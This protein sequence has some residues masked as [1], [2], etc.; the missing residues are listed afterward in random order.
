MG[1][2]G[3]GV[4][5]AELPGLAAKVYH[6]PRPEHGRRLE[7]MLAS[8][9]AGRPAFTWPVE[10]LRS[11]AGEVVG[12]LM[13]RLAP[14]R[15]PLAELFERRTRRV[16]VPHFTYRDLMAT[17]RSL[18]EC[19]AAV[20]RRGHVVGDLDEGDILAGPDARVTLVDTDSFQVTSP[21]TGERFRCTTAQPDLTPPELQGLRPADVDRAPEHDRFGL[22]VILFQL[23]MEGAHP[24][25]GVCAARGASPSRSERIRAGEFAY[26]PGGACRP[27]PLSPPF[28]LLDRGLRVLFTRCFVD[29]HLRPSAR[30]TP[31][32]WEHALARAEAELR[33][34]ATGPRHVYGSH[35]DACP[36][37]ERARLVPGG[38]PFP[39]NDD[40]LIPTSGAQSAGA[41]PPVPASAAGFAPP[42][43]APSVPPLSA[44]PVSPVSA[45][46][47]ASPLSAGP[48]VPPPL[49]ADRIP[50]PLP[51]DRVP[52]PIPADLIP[53]LAT[54]ADRVPPPIPTDLIPAQTASVPPPIPAD[55]VPPPLPPRHVPPPLP[56]AAPRVPPSV[57]GQPAAPGHA[58]PADARSG[59]NPFTGL[60]LLLAVAG[61][62][63][64]LR[65]VAWALAAVSAVL[66]TVFAHRW[67]GAGQLQV[68]AAAAVI[69]LTLFMGR[70][71]TP[72]DPETTR[73]AAAPSSSE[74]AP[75][76]DAR[77]SDEP[78][79]ASR[80]ETPPVR[81]PR[82]TREEATQD[83]PTRDEPARAAPKPTP[84]RAPKSEPT[85]RRTPRSELE[86]EP[87]PRRASRPEPTP[88]RAPKPRETPRTEPRRTPREPATAPS[89]TT[90]TTTTETRRTPRPEAAPRSTPAVTRRTPP[91]PA[92]PSARELSLVRAELAVAQTL[93]NQGA[94]YDA[95]ISLRN[96]QGNASSLAARYPNS[97]SVAELNRRVRTLTTE[98]RQAC[99]AEASIFRSRGE[100]TPPCP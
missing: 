64:P 80:A 74:T 83:E 98:N 65:G 35:L 72:P 12:Y 60:A 18:A 4:R 87:T 73:V 22:A 55:R 49:P 57:P 46:P 71:G 2:R 48:S 61:V 70:Q 8:P 30:P 95:G 15:V 39:P 50:P 1:E 54:A 93:K 96:A 52:P 32:E 6:T 19:V 11:P 28:E 51:A 25:A 84:R 90:R 86:P 43:G 59:V 79:D 9:P 40:T 26:A 77:P 62:I 82:A 97:A 42:V 38:D 53:S 14:D 88:R 41:V 10:V 56:S 69:G 85:P 44:A 16:H 23:L 3:R 45:A 75:D 81:P 68:V 5:P 63:P 24:F 27:A 76:R 21:A 94:Y 100:P 47:S 31:E 91:E 33:L 13:P 66:G 78:E 99:L 67:K 37:C 29:G 34:C 7:A 89:R 36:W 58:P 17:A 92:A 20:H